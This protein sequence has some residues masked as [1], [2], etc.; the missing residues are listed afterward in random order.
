MIFVGTVLLADLKVIQLTDSLESNV[1]FIAVASDMAGC[2]DYSKPTLDTGWNIETSLT[3]IMKTNAYKTH[4]ADGW[5]ISPYH[6]GSRMYRATRGVYSGCSTVDGHIGYYDII[7]Y[8]YQFEMQKNFADCVPTDPPEG[9]LL[10]QTNAT[11]AECTEDP[12][13]NFCSCPT[14]YDPVLFD[15]YK[16]QSDDNTTDCPS[17]Q[18]KDQFGVCQDDTN[19]NGIPDTEENGDVCTGEDLNNYKYLPSKLHNRVDYTSLTPTNFVVKEKCKEALS[20][21]GVDSVL[22]IYDLEPLC[23][24]EYCYY[25]ITD[26]DCA[27]LDYKDYYPSSDWVYKAV[28]SNYAC[29][30]FNDGVNYSSARFIV[31]DSDNCAD[32]SFCYVLPVDNNNSNP[33]DNNNSNPTDNN[34]SN[35]DN[36][37]SN[38]DLNTTNSLLADLLGFSDDNNKS[39]VIRNDLLS[40]IN[41][42]LVNSNHLLSDINNSLGALNSKNKKLDD[43]ISDSNLSWTKMTTEFKKFKDNLSGQ[44]D[45][46]QNDFD[47]IDNVWDGS[48]TWTVGGASDSSCFSVNV[49]GKTVNFDPCTYLSRFSGIF[50]IFIT[51]LFTVM[52]IKTISRTLEHAA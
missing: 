51:I 3:G 39:N 6:D 38:L 10:F 13:N 34:N 7:N 8:S 4:A 11:S 35:S 12:L 24:Y 45:R 52:A 21:P 25:Y 32:I 15:L 48:R 28:T 47:S 50:S 30:A 22:I 20:I 46:M 41:G 23:A 26:L 49:F 27:A 40:D 43:L 19:G 17:G 2:S 5:A 14:S 37:N 18:V 29:N 44:L 31:P 42:T 33:S 36:N 16:R 9:F 1:R